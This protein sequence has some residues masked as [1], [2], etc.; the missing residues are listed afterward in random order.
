MENRRV[1]SN[2]AAA[3]AEGLADDWTLGAW[4]STAVLEEVGDDMARL[5]EPQ[6]RVMVG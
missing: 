5:T 3:V 6:K 2:S 1:D 4:G